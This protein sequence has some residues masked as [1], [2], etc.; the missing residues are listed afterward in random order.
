MKAS[1]ER[2]DVPHG[3]G[4]YIREPDSQKVYVCWRDSRAVLVLSTISPGHSSTL[5]TWRTKAG[6]KSQRIQIPCSTVITNYNSH[7]GGVDKSDQFLAYHNVLRKTVRFWKTLFYHL[8]DIAVVNSSILYNLA[9]ANEGMKPISENDFRDKL[10]L[11]IIE[12]YG[13]DKKW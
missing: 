2:K 3:T 5:A 11:Q 10:V 8:V 12:K 4:Y 13:R 6:G 9:A 7:M 1:L